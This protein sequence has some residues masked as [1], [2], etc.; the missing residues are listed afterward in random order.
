VITRPIGNVIVIM[1]PYCVNENQLQ[2]ICSVLKR[3]IRTITEL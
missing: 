1:P 2:T 3:S